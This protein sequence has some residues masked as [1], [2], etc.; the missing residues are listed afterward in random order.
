M[1]RRVILS[2]SESTGVIIRLFDVSLQTHLVF[3]VL[4]HDM[5]K[6][7]TILMALCIVIHSVTAASVFCQDEREIVLL[8]N[9]WTLAVFTV[10][11]TK[12]PTT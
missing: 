5:V 10:P 12:L 8:I 11:F 4:P 7:R 1:M 3:V 2:F 9:G 6:L